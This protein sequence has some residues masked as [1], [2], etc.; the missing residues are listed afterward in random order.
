MF[1]SGSRN[2][3]WWQ[4]NLLLSFPIMG[5]VWRC[6]RTSSS[7][8]CFSNWGELLVRKR[9]FFF[10]LSEPVKECPEHIISSFKNT[11]CSVSWA[12][13]YYSAASSI[14]PSVSCAHCLLN[15]NSTASSPVPQGVFP[16]KPGGKSRGRPLLSRAQESKALIPL[17]PWTAP[18]SKEGSER[19]TG[20]LDSAGGRWLNFLLR[21]Y[22]KQNAEVLGMGEERKKK[23]T[24]QQQNDCCRERKSSFYWMMLAQ[25]KIIFFPLWLNF[26]SACILHNK[27]ID[28]LGLLFWAK[29][30]GSFSFSLSCS[31]LAEELF[32]PIQMDLVM[33]WWTQPAHF[34][35][36]NW[37]ALNVV[38]QRLL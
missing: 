18:V 22:P 27:A 13:K 7:G 20:V 1:C 21:V 33:T 26:S 11:T 12:V 23:S 35:C 30:W 2:V 19:G 15:I 17:G 4:E 32:R 5:V 24:A 25:M 28:A 3:A 9:D 8:E 36:R 16:W 29:L 6:K 37:S 10:F 31:R 14:P 38:W 34:G